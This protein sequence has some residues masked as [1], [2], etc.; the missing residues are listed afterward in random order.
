MNILRKFALPPA[1][2]LATVC[3]GYAMVVID[4]TAVNVALP[5]IGDELAGSVT[6]L[7]WVVDGY[8]LV[9]AALLVAGGS[10]GD[11][12][13]PARV[14]TVGVVVFGVASAA[15]AVAPCATWS[16][17]DTGTAWLIRLSVS[18]RRGW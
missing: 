12:F 18:R 7:Q 2:V 10:A 9:F 4:T 15:C 3:L 16:V 5:T 11:R 14:F 17:P 6:G 1:G 8:V 13:G